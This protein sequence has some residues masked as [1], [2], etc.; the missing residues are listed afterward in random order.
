MTFN[1]YFFFEIL[2]TGLSEKSQLYDTNIPFWTKYEIY[3][4]YLCQRKY[5]QESISMFAN[6]ILFVSPRRAFS[7]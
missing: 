3:L 2:V 1:K 7:S 5:F 6:W 4:Q